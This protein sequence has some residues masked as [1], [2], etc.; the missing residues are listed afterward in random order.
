VAS[1]YFKKPTDESIRHI[2]SHMRKEDVIEIKAANNLKP[3]ESLLKAVETSTACVVVWDDKEP[4]AIFGMGTVSPMTGTAIIWLLGTDASLK[5]PRAFMKYPRMVIAEMLKEAKT[6]T[7]YV[8]VRNTV[9]VKWLKALGFNMGE[10]QKLGMYNEPFQ[11][12][13]M[14]RHTNV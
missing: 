11:K 2:A 6:L 14:E 5:Y 13:T 3:L 7:N 4:L 10:V 8:H 1:L 12:F 9:S